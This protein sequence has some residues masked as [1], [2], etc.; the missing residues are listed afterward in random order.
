[1]AVFPRNPD[2]MI[3]K[4]GAKLGLA[5]YYRHKGKPA[6]REYFC[7]CYWTQLV[8]RKVVDGWREFAQDLTGVVVGQRSNTDLGNRF[9]YIW[10]IEAEGMPDIFVAICEFGKGVAVCSIVVAP[11]VS[12]ATNQNG[13][14]SVRDL[15]QGVEPKEW[16]EAY[17]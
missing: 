17:N 10:G 16:L 6:P 8:N 1:M 4:V 5:L 9:R 12:E 3:R 13:W 2:P 7:A 14:I 11:A 15:A